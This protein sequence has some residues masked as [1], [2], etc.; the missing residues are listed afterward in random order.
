MKE[1]KHSY[2]HDIDWY[3][4][5]AKDIDANVINDK[6]I[7]FPPDIGSGT[8]YFLP[9]TKG[10]SVVVIDAIF[11]NDIVV[12]RLDSHND[13]YILHFDLSEKINRVNLINDSSCELGLNVTS[14]FSVFH[15]AVGSVLQPLKN[16]RIFTVRIL[17]D[18]SKLID[19]L[20]KKDKSL[21]NIEKRILFYNHLNAQSKILIN[22]LKVRSVFDTD[23]ELYL[24]G[25]TMKLLANFIDTYT[26]P[27]KKEMRSSQ[28]QALRDTHDFLIKNVYGKF[29]GLK[30]LARMSRTSESL[31]KMNFKALYDE[32]PYRYFIKEKMLQ[33]SKLL[34]SGAFSTIREI[35]IMLN[36]EDLSCFNAKYS[37]IFGRKA[38]AD[39]VKKA[40]GKI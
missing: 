23:F 20:I 7:I 27:T 19:Y 1:L 30:A 6:I 5:C 26:H 37:E 3:H 35:Y 17:I 16:R 11:T 38:S 31:F 29:P 2:S 8:S 10:V 28:K 9:V 32:T 18:R 34:K 25:I 40:E 36:F 15:S 21:K 39:F 14:G 22:T 24:K 33:A 13:L 4:K 12:K